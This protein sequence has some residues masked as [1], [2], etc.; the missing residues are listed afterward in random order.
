MHPIT[1]L[2]DAMG[3]ERRSECSGRDGPQGAAR[4]RN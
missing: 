4:T 1:A 3:K 2:A